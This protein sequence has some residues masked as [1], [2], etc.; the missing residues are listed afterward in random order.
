MIEFSKSDFAQAEL[1]LKELDK[2]FMK[3]VKS[4]LH[5]SVDKYLENTLNQQFAKLK[6]AFKR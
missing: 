6:K 5:K 3:T 2:E 4:A 1:L